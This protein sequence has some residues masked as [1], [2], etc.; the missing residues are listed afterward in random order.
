MEFEKLLKELQDIVDRLDDPKTG[1][2]EGLALFDRGI[3]VSKECLKVLTEN[4]GKVEQASH[5]YATRLEP[6]DTLMPLVVL[7]DETTASAS[8]I[9]SGA[10]QDLDRA[11]VMGVRTYGK[12][13][14]QVPIDLP[15]NTNVKITVSKYFIPSGRCIQAINYTREGGAGYKEHIP[16]SLTHVFYTRAGREV[17]D[18]GGIKPDVEVKN[19]TMPN[20]SY[21]LSVGGMDS[22][23]VMFDYVVDYIAR[24]DS[25]APPAQ[26]R[27]TDEDWQE[28]R[29]R[30]ID[31]GFTY[32]DMSRKEFDHLVQTAKFE[33]YYEEARE[34]F[35]ALSERL[36]HQLGKE[37]DRHREVIQH[38][39]ELNIVGAYYYQAGGIEA[40]LGSDKQVREAERLLK[41]EQE[42]RQILKP[43]QHEKH[44]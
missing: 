37:L 24:H 19:D 30:V 4:R 2:D 29:Q 22:T 3:K 34:A 1:L 44:D 13:L 40:E 28:F 25:I 17:R 41:N 14:V 8:E 36:H 21:Y 12:G 43:Q 33:G 11:V 5:T 39:I 6:V 20:I 42:Y 9:T 26:F 15:Y 35:D 31:S 18:G 38:L 16:D 27:L 32:D 10:L 23:E 7:V